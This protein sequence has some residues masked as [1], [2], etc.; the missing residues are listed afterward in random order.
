M[1]LEVVILLE[2][3]EVE[4]LGESVAGAAGGLGAVGAGVGPGSLGNEL[5]AREGCSRE[6]HNSSSV[7]SVRI[8]VSEFALGLDEL[9]CEDVTSGCEK[10]I[11]LNVGKGGG[12]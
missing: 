8:S 6:G 9:S 10:E 4:R 2:S 1:L 11:D 7:R 5:E 3:N 12:N